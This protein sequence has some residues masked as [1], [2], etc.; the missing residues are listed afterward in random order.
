MDVKL[1][2]RADAP[3]IVAKLSEL[4]PVLEVRWSD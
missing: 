3:G 4:E 2:P 1:P